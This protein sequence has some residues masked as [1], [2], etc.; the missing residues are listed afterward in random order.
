MCLNHTRISP[1]FCLNFYIRKFWG[2]TVPPPPP[3]PPV[4][5][6]YG[7]DLYNCITYTSTYTYLVLYS[8]FLTIPTF[9]CSDFAEQWNS[10]SYKRDNVESL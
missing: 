4:S 1:D 7:T 3:P 6:A 10:L 8:N 2:G 5:Y 9:S